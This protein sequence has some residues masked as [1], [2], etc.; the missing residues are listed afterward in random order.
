M[1]DRDA[2]LGGIR[3][4]LVVNRA[5]LEREAE[6]YSHGE[7]HPQGPFT[8]SGLSVVEQ[9]TAELEALTGHVHFCPDA[10]AALARVRDLLRSHEV[11]QLLHW[12]WSE[13]PLPGLQEVCAELGIRSAEGQLNG[14]PD[15][16]ERLLALEPVPFCISG[17][18]AAIAESGTLVVLTGA[19]RG[20]LASLLPPIHLA[21]F[22]T[23]RIVRTLPEAFELLYARYGRDVVHERSNLSL[24]SGPSRTADIEQ[25]L[26]LGVHGPKEIHVVIFDE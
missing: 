17:A 19:G 4:S 8:P 2:I 11:D 25:S 5:M 10:T 13:I 20:R 21:I 26:T 3:R 14:A 16:A 23:N 7:P 1:S 9:F 6:E 22:P 24:I 18:D 12:D 15:R